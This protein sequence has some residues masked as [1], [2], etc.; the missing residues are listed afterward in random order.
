[1]HAGRIRLRQARLTTE[2]AALVPFAALGIVLDGPV[3]LAA[4]AVTRRVPSPIWQATAKALT[5]FLLLPILWGTETT[6]V[7]RRW[8]GKAALATAAAGPVGGLAWIAWR[9]R[10]LRLR[11]TR[12]SI[13]WFAKPNDAL[14][15]ARASREAVL[16]EVTRLIGEPAVARSTQT[17]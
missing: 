8:G 6:L 9:T 2:T 13:E 4:H 12:R 14:Q 16:D 17:I 5:G 11:Q 3:V 10:W 7:Y 15:A 1:M